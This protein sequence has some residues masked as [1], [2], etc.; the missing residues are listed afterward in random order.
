MG[1]API[2]RLITVYAEAE[3]TQINGT[4]SA[5]TILKDL[6]W[7]IIKYPLERKILIGLQSCE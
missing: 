4:E 1:V 7:W 2:K 5:S 3:Q 6:I